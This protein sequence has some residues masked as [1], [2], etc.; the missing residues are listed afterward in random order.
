MLYVT[1]AA[2]E[3]KLCVVDV[4][5]WKI[6]GF[7]DAGHTAIAPVVS[8]DGKTLFVCNQFNDDVSVIDLVAGKEL[9]RIPVSR[10]PVAADL[11]RDGKY[12]LVANQLPAGRADT[13]TVA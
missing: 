9:R 13:G 4:A 10:Q 8:R 5:G 11:T 6:R 1:C 2:S 12:L 7:L 3:S